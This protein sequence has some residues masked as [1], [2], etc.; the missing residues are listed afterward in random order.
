MDLKEFLTRIKSN[1]FA[2]LIPGFYILFFIVVNGMCLLDEK[3]KTL[4]PI[5]L[6]SGISNALIID[7]YC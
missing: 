5:E 6:L 1:F 2:I 7:R 4:S 3:M